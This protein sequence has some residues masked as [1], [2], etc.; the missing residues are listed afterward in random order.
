MPSQV[1]E[2]HLLHAVWQMFR[3]PEH[4]VF[5]QRRQYLVGLTRPA[6]WKPPSRVTRAR[7]LPYFD[8]LGGLLNAVVIVRR[9]Q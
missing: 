1:T 2:R 8:A 5:R 7:V 4:R 6:G 3:R 9:R